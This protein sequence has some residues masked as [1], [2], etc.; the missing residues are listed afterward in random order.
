[1]GFELVA[2]KALLLATGLHKSQ[3]KCGVSRDSALGLRAVP[4]GYMLSS[5]PRAAWVRPFGQD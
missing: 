3:G 1:M 4:S 2:E 5:G